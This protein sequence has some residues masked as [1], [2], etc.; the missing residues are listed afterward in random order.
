MA[1]QPVD[2]FQSPCPLPANVEQIRSHDIY[3][4]VCQE[5]P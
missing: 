4:E 3:G 5:A 2:Q 1:S